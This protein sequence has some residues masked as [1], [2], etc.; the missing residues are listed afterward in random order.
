MTVSIRLSTMLTVFALIGGC[1]SDVAPAS[2]S[3]DDD[4]TTAERGDA[5]RGRDA[6]RAGDA[7]VDAAAAGDD[8]DR[9]DDDGSNEDGDAGLVVG[10]DAG[11]SDASV[12]DAGTRDAAVADAGRPSN[13][14]GA[15]ACDKLTY[16]SFGQSFM[17]SYCVSCHGGAN[18]Q[19][20]VRLDT[21]AGVT[22]AKS[23]VKAEVGA[24]AMPPRG[25]KA[26][27]AA[28]RAQLTQWIDCGP[29]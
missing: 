22:A 29:K 4:E 24:G 17:S 1:G 20:E 2:P 23:K 26:P 19:K 16:A 3:D 28:E 15:S 25:A 7:R 8:D 13:D 6:G 5:G 14:A 18:A 21:L 27:T 9:S 12:R 11:R 10:R